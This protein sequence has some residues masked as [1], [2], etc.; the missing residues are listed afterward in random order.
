MTRVCKAEYERGE[1]NTGRDFQY[2]DKHSCV[3]KLL[4]PKKELP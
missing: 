2:I 1:Q 3:R 4:R